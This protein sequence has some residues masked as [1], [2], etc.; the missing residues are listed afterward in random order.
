MPLILRPEVYAEWID[1]ENKKPGRIEP[2]LKNGCVQELKR[3]PVSKRVNHVGNN[4]KE[5][6]EPLKDLI[7]PGGSSLTHGN[8]RQ[9]SP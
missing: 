1:P 8:G 3:N 9:L 6:M 2:V 7:W 5:C 4:S